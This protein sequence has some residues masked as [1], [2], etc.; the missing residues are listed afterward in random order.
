MIVRIEDAED[1]DRMR[2]S[3]CSLGSRLL[4]SLARHLNVAHSR[5]REFITDNLVV[6]IFCKLHTSVNSYLS[7]LI[8]LA[9][10]QTR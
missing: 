4:A 10:I 8:C 7:P 6:N 5:G 9:N 1:A 2:C 3:L